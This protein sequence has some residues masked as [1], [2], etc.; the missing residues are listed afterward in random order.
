MSNYLDN[1]PTLL[2]EFGKA[3]K[4]PIELDSTGKANLITG[5]E[6]IRQSILQIL[7][8]PYGTRYYLYDFGSKLE[9]VIDEPDY[10]LNSIVNYYI[11]EPLNKYEKRVELVS[12]SIISNTLEKTE[13]QLTYKLTRL[14][15]VDTFVYPFYKTLNT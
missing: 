14:N 11:I 3:L 12:S 4:F 8:W 2:N 9:T 15:L 5:I 10:N 1:D 7:S 6:L 13:I